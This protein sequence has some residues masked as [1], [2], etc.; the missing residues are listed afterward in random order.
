MRGSPEACTHGAGAGLGEGRHRHARSR[1]ARP[2]RNGAGLRLDGARTTACGWLCRLKR[3]PLGQGAAVGG[4]GAR[5]HTSKER[6]QKSKQKKRLLRA[7]RE[8]V[9]SRALRAQR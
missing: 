9:A 8:L 3:A 5:A 1:S 2:A 7:G 4:G 6:A